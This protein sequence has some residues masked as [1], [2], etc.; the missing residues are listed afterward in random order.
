MYRRAARLVGLLLGG[1]LGWEVAFWIPGVPP[2]WTHMEFLR[3]G[4][5][6]TAL[7]ALIGYF[8][9]PYITIRP[10]QAAVS[11][12]RNVP[13]TDLI[14][15]SVGL[16]VGLVISAILAIPLSR[17]PSP[18]GSLLPLVG[19]IIFAYLGVVAAVLRYRDLL[20]LWRQRGFRLTPKGLSKRWG[21]MPVLLD[22]SVIIDGRIADIVRTGFIPGPLLVPRFV[23]NELQYIADSGD[24]LRRNRGRRGLEIL[25]ELQEGRW[26][27]LEIIEDDVNEVKQVDEKLLRLARRLGCPI[28]TNDY[29]LNRVAT[30]QNV[31]VLN[32]NELA[33]A[34]KTV[35]L[36]G[37]SLDIHLIQEGKEPGQGVGYLDDGTMVVVQDGKHYIGETV[38][39]TVTKVLQTSA[40][41]M[42]F[43]V[44]A[45]QSAS[46]TG[47]DNQR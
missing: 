18:F 28:L 4:I 25:H 24:P 41:R 45:D 7:G 33:N 12:L 17:L 13:L 34:V 6:L 15:G 22:T 44:L 31:E 20:E 14:A 35:L 47:K 9:F 11:W 40:G 46:D 5:P 1:V 30:L 26:V 43:A 23:L 2:V 10:A 39:V 42:I 8:V 32:I 16:L 3:W 37:E 38:H 21:P 36:P 29:N 19:A 27:T